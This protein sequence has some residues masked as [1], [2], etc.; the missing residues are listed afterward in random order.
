MSREEDH[1]QTQTKMKGTLLLN[2]GEVRSLLTLA[3]YLE[4]VEAAF[5]LHG[6]GRI[7]S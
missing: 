5:K 6:E 2:R 1:M 4:T 7:F 3:D